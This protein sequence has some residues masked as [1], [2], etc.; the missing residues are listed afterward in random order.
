L[1]SLETCD[2]VCL[3]LLLN[4]KSAHAGVAQIRQVRN[5]G[6]N[7]HREKRP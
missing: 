3:G 6:T 2:A 4:R 7:K 5:P 1:V